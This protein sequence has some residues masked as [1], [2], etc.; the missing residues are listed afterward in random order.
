M[1]NRNIKLKDIFKV[2]ITLIVMYQSVKG[3]EEGI[4]TL[5]SLGA[6]YIE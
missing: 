2:L 5:S 3:I 6:K 1:E 4:N